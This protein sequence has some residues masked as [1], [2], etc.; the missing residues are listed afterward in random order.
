[1]SFKPKIDFCG[2]AD[3]TSIVLKSHTEGR[4]ST[5]VTC[6]NDEGDTV[7]A[8][9]VG[10]VINP[11]NEYALKADLTN[12]AIVLGSV[13]T[14]NLGT[15]QSPNNHYFA[16]KSV[17]INTSNSGAVAISAQSEE[18]PSATAKRTYTVTIAS[19]KC[20]VKAQILNSLFTLTGEKAHL[21]SANY[22]FSVEINHTPVD[23]ER[24]TFDVYGGK[25]VCGCEAKQAGTVA[26]VIAPGSSD[27]NVTILS[28]DNSETRPDS[29][30]ASVSAEVTKYL[31]AD[32]Q[33]SSTQ[34]SSGT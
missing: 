12:F 29:D 5:T 22:T 11:S 8:T 14:V 25:V 27:T 28:G 34:Q 30:Y 20:R 31:T 1:M 4:S 17:A 18:V 32:T 23:G 21:Q 9:I 2:L 24:I 19:L 7:D 16:L 15:E 6:E 33:Q 13:T 3:G 10:H 26:P